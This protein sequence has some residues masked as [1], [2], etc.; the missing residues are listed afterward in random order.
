MRIMK[1]LFYVSVLTML[2]NILVAPR[3]GGGYSGFQV[4]GTIE[5]EQKSCKTKKGLR[6][7][8]ETKK[9]PGPKLPN[10]QAI[11]I[12]RKHQNNITI[13]N[14][15]IVLNTPKNP[16]LSQAAKKNKLAK[17]LKSK[18]SNPPKKSFD[19]PFT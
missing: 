16:Y 10:F 18:I 8:N 3:G 15:Q 1:P 4:T 5:W 12:S 19:H 2:I 7:S 14:L 6:A 11:N 9:I 17:I 13:T